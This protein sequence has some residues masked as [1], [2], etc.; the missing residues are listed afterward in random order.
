[1]SPLPYFREA[2]N[3]PGVV[4][5][6]SNASS[7]GQWRA[8]ME[9]LATGFHVLAPDS[10]GAGK[11]P[12][13]PPEREVSLQDEINLLEPVFLR[14]GSPRALVGHSYGA[15]VALVAAVNQPGRVRALALYEP[16]LLGYPGAVHDG[17]GLAGFFSERGSPA[18]QDLA[19]SGS[20]GVPGSR[21]HGP[22]HSPA[23]WSTR[24]SPAFLNRP[25]PS[26]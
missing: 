21:P 10:Y 17:G 2:G 23:G 6:H 19:T 9:T 1:M 4:C 15:A 22:D 16:T 8:L 25:E 14:A 20:A 26:T 7:S 13:W 12:P 3:G 5:L 24:P 18:H 11:S